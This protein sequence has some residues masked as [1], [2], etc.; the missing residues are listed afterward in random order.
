MPTLT[1]KSQVTIPKAVRKKAGLNPGDEVEIVF[2]NG[3]VLLRKRKSKKSV[4]KWIGFLGQES[5]R[6][7]M[8]KLRG[9]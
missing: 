3:S 9:T 6:E 4:K 7:V 2:K 1:V 5:T 8:K